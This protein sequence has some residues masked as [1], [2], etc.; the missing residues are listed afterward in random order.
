MRTESENPISGLSILLRWYEVCSYFWSTMDPQECTITI[1]V[2]SSPLPIY[3]A[4][5]Y[6]HLYQIASHKLVI[7]ALSTLP[8]S[9]SKSFTSI[10]SRSIFN[11]NTTDISLLSSRNYQHGSDAPGNAPAAQ[12]LRYLYSIEAQMQPRKAGLPTL[13]RPWLPTRLQLQRRTPPGKAASN[14]YSLR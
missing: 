5:D 3:R 6:L 13:R 8:H 4:S 11:F 14:I 12:L 10:C 9:H 2:N 1:P 7:I